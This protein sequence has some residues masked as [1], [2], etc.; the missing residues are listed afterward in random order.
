MLVVESLAS[1]KLNPGGSATF[2][3]TAGT[4]SLD[5]TGDA[6]PMRVTAW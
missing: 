2:K 4:A 5:L 3:L 1:K 6:S